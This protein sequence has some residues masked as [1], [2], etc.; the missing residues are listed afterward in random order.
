MLPDGPG[1][2]K[3]QAAQRAQFPANERNFEKWLFSNLAVGSW[4][5]QIHKNASFDFKCARTSPKT[6]KVCI[7]TAYLLHSASGVASCLFQASS[8]SKFHPEIVG[9]DE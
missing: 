7:L 4:S 1:M 6:V 9:R 2:R 3:K 5:L 8:G